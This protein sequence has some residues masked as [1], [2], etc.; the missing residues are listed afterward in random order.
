MKY[1]K[2]MCLDLHLIDYT[3]MQMV[4]LLPP[5]VFMMRRYVLDDGI[6]GIAL[7]GDRGPS[8]A[9]GLKGGPTEKHGVEGPEGPPGKIGKMG[10]VGSRG[11]IGAHGEKG[12]NGDSRG[13][14]Q[15]GT[16][17]PQSSMGRRGVEGLN[18]GPLG[19]QGPIGSTGG[20]GELGSKRGKGIQGS[21][22]GKGDH[23]NRGERVERDVKGEQGI[24]G[25][26]SYVLIVLADHLPIQ[27]ATRYGKKMCFVKYHVSE[28]RLSI[29]EFVE[30][31]EC[32][33]MFAH[34][35]N[36][37]GILMLKLWMVKVM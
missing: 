30:V 31:W 34:T 37:L 24:Q 20:E 11:G 29:I 32:H 33:V 2:A 21:V 18:G 6:S 27:L 22:G 28:D 19:M 17:G 35:M 14:G 1:S 12:D 5:F 25:D 13:V 23:G 36:P 9:R 16:I 15:Q 7:Q 3:R 26:N 4:E 10:S 8:G